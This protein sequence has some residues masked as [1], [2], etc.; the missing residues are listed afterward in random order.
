MTTTHEQLAI[1]RQ[2]LLAD[3]FTVQGST[4]THPE[5]R[6]L[7]LNVAYAH[8]EATLIVSRFDITGTRRWSEVD[9]YRGEHPLTWAKTFYKIFGVS[10]DTGPSNG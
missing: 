1:I 8:R 4:Y 3:G 9:R 6:G 2:A 10:P 5:R 7:R